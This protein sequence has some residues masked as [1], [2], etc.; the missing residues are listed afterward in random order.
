MEEEHRLLFIP[1]CNQS[2]Q[3][4]V[5]ATSRAFTTTLQSLLET[6]LLD[7]APDRPLRLRCA[8][9]EAGQRWKAVRSF[10]SY[11]TKIR[12]ISLRGAKLSVDEL[13]DLLAAAPSIVEVDVTF[14]LPLAWREF[15][16]FRNR[17]AF[18]LYDTLEAK[19]EAR[20]T[21]RDVVVAQ[22]YGLHCHRVDVCFRFASP[23]N[24]ARTGPLERFVQFFESPSRFSSML[25]CKSFHI[26]SE[27]LHGRYD[28]QRARA[29]FQLTF[30]TKEG[31]EFFFAWELSRQVEQL[32]RGCWMTDGVV[33]M[34]LEAMWDGTM[35]EE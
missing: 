35:A 11:H 8:A 1:F 3:L 23:A 15:S 20:H 26:D 18:R 13:S 10:L 34:D 27:Q 17:C 22:A 24:K 12:R 33:P 9:A 4:R 32:Y 25:G 31:Q 6:L 2:E 29:T 7:A 28:L 14:A 5:R 16:E 21:P 19:P 30:V